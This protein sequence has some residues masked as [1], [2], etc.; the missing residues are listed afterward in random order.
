MPRHKDDFQFGTQ[1][2]ELFRQL[3]AVHHRHHDI[4]Y[5]QI[6]LF[7]LA[8]PLFDCFSAVFRFPDAVAGFAEYFTQHS[9]DTVLV[10][11]EQDGLGSLTHIIG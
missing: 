5:D 1:A 9:P 6:D 4:R 10:L 2:S 8:Y 11:N 7:D 3:E